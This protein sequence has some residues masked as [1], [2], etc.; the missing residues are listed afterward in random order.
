MNK[1]YKLGQGFS[2]CTHRVRPDS[3]QKL[4]ATF[5]DFAGSD[6][7]IISAFRLLFGNPLY[8][9]VFLQDQPVNTAQ[10]A[11]LSSIA[12]SSLSPSLAER[13]ILFVK[14]YFGIAIETDPL[15]QAPIPAASYIPPPIKRTTREANTQSEYQSISA[16]SEESTVF[17]DDPP[18]NEPVDSQVEQSSRK[19]VN[20]PHA[21]T[22]NLKTL[23]LAVLLFVLGFS[24]FR[25][26]AICEPFGLCE[27][28]K[29][30]VG[31][32]S[33]IAPNGSPTKGKS[34]GDQAV[35]VTPLEPSAPS[36]SSAPF[37]SPPASKTVARPAP[38][39]AP[40]PAYTPPPPR[41][42]APLRDEPLW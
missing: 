3:H 22:V 16:A 5:G 19:S 9:S 23:F 2:D 12:N 26:P 21:K 17:A 25:V 32:D 13:A 4:L 42:R 30:R 34:V 8:I 37:A 24:I 33:R 11:A 20:S 14:G 15:E 38:I 1:D 6:H 39:T 36:E 7:E 28:K 31:K 18:S 40:Q 10:I 41:E 27:K 35:P 29:D